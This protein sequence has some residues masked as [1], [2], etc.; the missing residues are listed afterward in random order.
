MSDESK[1]KELSE[2]ILTTL[3]HEY[4]LRNLKL[5]LDALKSYKVAEG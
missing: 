5:I 1:L 2:S 3:E 4:L